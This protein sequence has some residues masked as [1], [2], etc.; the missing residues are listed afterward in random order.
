MP[1]QSSKIASLYFA[2]RVI[3]SIS[4]HLLAGNRENANAAISLIED[5]NLEN[6][7]SQLLLLLEDLSRQSVLYSTF[8]FFQSDT[9]PTTSTSCSPTCL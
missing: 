3:L 4:Q 2:Q 9:R 5:A 7:F 1:L 8:S 6:F